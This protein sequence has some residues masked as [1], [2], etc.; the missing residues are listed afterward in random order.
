LLTAAAVASFPA[1]SARYAVDSGPYLLA[2]SLLVWGWIWSTTRSRV[3]VAV[4]CLAVGA[5]I[6]LNTLVSFTGNS[7]WLKERNGPVYARIEQAFLPLQR[8]WFDHNP[9]RYGPA[10]LQVRFKDGMMRHSEVLL[11]AGGLYRHNALCIDYLGARRM[12]LRFHQRGGN[13]PLESE[14]IHFE[15][16]QTYDLE[17]EMGS[18]YPVTRNVL[19]RMY[20]GRGLFER[21]EQLRVRVDG[22]EV[23]R[24]SYDFV[25]SPPERVTFGNETVDPQYCSV[26]FSGEILRVDRGFP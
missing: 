5:Q 3:F 13:P 12:R 2:A 14:T 8:V 17:V 9:R 6:V 11:A 19:E 1:V 18:L 22:T 7:D 26:P 23:L 24:N 15:P 10:R 25:P 21:A 20:P 4:S 16:G